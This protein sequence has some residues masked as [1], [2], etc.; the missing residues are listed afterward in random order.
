MATSASNALDGFSFIG[1]VVIFYYT[2]ASLL[3]LSLGLLQLLQLL[4]LGKLFV[5]GVERIAAGD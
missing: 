1:G 3:L 4:G 5:V 2:A